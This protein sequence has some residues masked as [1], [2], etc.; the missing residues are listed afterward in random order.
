MLLAHVQAAHP[1]LSLDNVVWVVPAE[2]NRRKGHNYLTM[3]ADPLAKRVFVDTRPVR[4]PPFG[5]LLLVNCC[6]ATG[7]LSLSM[8]WP[9]T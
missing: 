5:R 2:I 3:F 1:R 8:T 6:G 7:I 9:S 4:T